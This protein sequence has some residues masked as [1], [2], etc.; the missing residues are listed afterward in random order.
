M[1]DSSEQLPGFLELP[2]GSKPA[3]TLSALK[4]QPL[5]NW[6]DRI[7]YDMSKSFGMP[8]G[9]SISWMK[10][11][12]NPGSKPGDKSFASGSLLP[13]R[14]IHSLIYLTLPEDTMF[15]S[16]ALGKP[17]QYANPTQG[18]TFAHST[19]FRTVQ[20]KHGAKL[21]P[22]LLSDQTTQY[23][24]ASPATVTRH[25]NLDKGKAPL[26]PSVVEERVD[27][28]MKPPSGHKGPREVQ[29][30]EPELD[31]SDE[32]ED[33]RL[34]STLSVQLK[35]VLDHFPM[36]K[37]K[38]MQKRLQLYVVKHLQLLA[39]RS[40]HVS[41]L[42]LAEYI[43]LFTWIYE[44]E[45]NEYIKRKLACRTATSTATLAEL[46]DYDALLRHCKPNIVEGM[47]MLNAPQQVNKSQQ[48]FWRRQNAAWWQANTS[49]MPH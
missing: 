12:S 35:L 18:S 49:G 1:A 22:E 33:T 15:T 48:D 32:E 5:P 2:N 10:A 7:A 34:L 40:Q 20:P 21:G 42:D 16:G 11:I 13:A 8:G 37:K 44:L 6:D 41:R 47:D 30:P 28:G 45:L 36:V 17:V 38:S 27:S 25:G 43:K 26:A 4:Y 14:N 29:G 24:G 19:P 31:S 46:V 23:Q 39:A 9:L 3:E